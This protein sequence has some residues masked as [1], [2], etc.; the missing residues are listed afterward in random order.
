MITL[1]LPNWLYPNNIGDTLVST[2]IPKLLKKVYPNQQLQ[3]V[4]YGKV[5]DILNKDANIDI[6]RPPFQEEASMDFASYANSEEQDPNIKVAVAGWH[7]RLFSFWKENYD[8]L[9]KHPTANILTVNFLLQLKLEH[10]LFDEDYDFRPYC[11]MESQFEPSDTFK[12]GIVIATKLAGKSNPHPGCNGVGY[13]YKLEYWSEFVKTIKELVPNVEVYEFSEN[14]TGIGDK[15]CP[16][17]DSFLDLFTQIDAL[18]LG[19]MSDGGIHHA[20]N[21]RNKPVVL[22]QPNILSKVEFMQLSNSHYPEHLHLDCR[23]SC[24]SYFT[25]VFGGEDKS[26]QC[27]MECE[28]LDPVG[29]AE[30]ASTVKQIKQTSYDSNN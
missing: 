4:S 6:C 13:R 24:R 17:T 15:H 30:Y 14:F 8:T 5:M 29:L 19:V 3:V 2:F 20:F 23:K 28:Q 27:N 11:N 26:K 25:E 16:Y 21:V 9:V 10:L 18:D 7:P 22:F 12:I 1:V